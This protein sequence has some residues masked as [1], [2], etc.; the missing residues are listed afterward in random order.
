MNSDEDEICFEDGVKLKLGLEKK[1]KTL[2]MCFQI[3]KLFPQKYQP[4]NNFHY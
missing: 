2:T 1:I 3:K 4:A